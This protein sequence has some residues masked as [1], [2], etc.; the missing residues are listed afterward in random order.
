MPVAWTDAVP[1]SREGDALIDTVVS[2]PDPCLAP[3]V[4]F[5]GIT[6]NGDRWFAVNS[7]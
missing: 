2:L 1:Y 4:F 6:P 7:F 3:I 5:A